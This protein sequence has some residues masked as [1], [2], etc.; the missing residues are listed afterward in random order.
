MFGS[1]TISGHLTRTPQLTQSATGKLVTTLCVAVDDHRLGDDVRYVDIDQWE[2]AAAPA[3][4]H[5]VQGQQITAEGLVDAVPYLR[6]GETRIQWRLKGARVQW[7]GR[8]LSS[9]PLE[10]LTDELQRRGAAAASAVPLPVGD[11]PTR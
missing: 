5:L 11:A 3:A 9:R 8:P 4:E 10:Q 7:G 1:T 2:D 6:D